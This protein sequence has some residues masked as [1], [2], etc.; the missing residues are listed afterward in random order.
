MRHRLIV[1]GAAALS[2]LLAIPASA[3]SYAPGAPGA[4]DSY[5][6]ESG[7][8]GYDVSHYDLRLKY[9]PTT[10]LLEGTATLLA[11]T[12]QDL[13]RFNLDFGLKVSEIRVNGKKATFATSGKHELEIT[14]ATPLPKGK[15]I[16]VVVRYAGK[17]S[18]LKIDGYSAWHRTPDGGVIAQEPDSAV[19]WFPSNDH[20]TDKAT[21]DIS[22]SVPDGNQALSNGVLLSQTSKLGWTRFNWRSDKPQA[23][24]LTTL[25]VGKFDVTKDTTASGLPVINAVSKDLGSYEGSARASIE[26]TTEVTEWLE[27]VFGPYPFNSV[28][29]YVPNVKAGYALE[30]QTRPFYGKERSPTA[31]TSPWW[32]TR[33]RTSGTATASRSRTGRTSGST[34]LRPLQP[35][36]VVGEGG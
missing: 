12:T 8:G 16:S 6:P 15:D 3:A 31:P 34:R 29:G 35:V 36:A 21:Y 30:T 13:N 24:Y 7:N 32:C 5:Y 25:A 11:K 22:V 18:E 17:P 14:P 1:P 9:Q 26:R 28:G 19:W 23:P 2:L 10:D 33:S 27:S 4:G 20:P